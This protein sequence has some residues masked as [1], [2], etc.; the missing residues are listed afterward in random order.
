MK[1]MFSEIISDE[2]IL[3]G[4]QLA[5]KFELPFKQSSNHKYFEVGYLFI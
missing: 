1:N 2:M 3:H 4:A 5:N